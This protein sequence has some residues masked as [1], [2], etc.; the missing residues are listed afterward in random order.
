MDVMRRNRRER[1]ESGAST[2]WTPVGTMIDASSSMTF[3]LA[4]TPIPF[5]PHRLPEMYPVWVTLQ[6][7]LNTVA[8]RHPR[9]IASRDSTPSSIFSPPS[10][11]IHPFAAQ[12]YRLPAKRVV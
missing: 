7:S 6:E 2:L 10:Q 3:H 8:P 9:R 11:D 5:T 4:G 1:R 12:S